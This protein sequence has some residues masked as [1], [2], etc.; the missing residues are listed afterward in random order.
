MTDRARSGES[1]TQDRTP[2]VEDDRKPDSPTDLS[3][4]SWAYVVRKTMR[5]F[6]DD[7]C[8]DL[9]A[10]LTYYAVLALF[11][12]AIAL[13]SLL[14][15]VGQGQSAVDNVITVLTPLVSSSTLDTVQPALEHIATSQ[16]AGLGL[17]LGI[18]GALW[19]ASGY[20]GAFGRAMNAVYEIDEGRPFWKLR[21]VMLVVTLV[22]ILLVAVVL[23]MLIVSGPLASSIGA[24]LGLSTQAVTAWNIV[25]W[26]VIV[27]FVVLI[28]AILYYTTPNVKQP[29]F[30]WLSL[31]A[32]VAILVWIMASAAFAFYVST[33]GSYDKTY[34]S[35]AGAVVG[36][37]WLWITNLALLFGAEL[38]SELE[39]GRQ[40]QAGIAAEEELQLPARDTR[41]ITKARKKE[42]KDLARG[43]AIRE[44]ADESTTI[45]TREKTS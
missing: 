6:G 4:R 10:A 25:K 30:R 18:V 22:A 13:I 27:L 1:R 8:T 45:D 2:G 15:V 39:R 38:D 37:L 26:P 29:K 35:L 9:A 36:L 28:V 7:H 31:G 17:V 24:L 33:F 3:R 14:G 11:P 5:E 20:V 41:G 19:S 16:S 34:G 12:A 44:E 21:P 43:R 23:V 40:L 42:Q 32:I